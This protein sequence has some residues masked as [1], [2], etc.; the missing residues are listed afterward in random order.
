MYQDER[1]KE[2]NA[3]KEWKKAAVAQKVIGLCGG[4]VVIGFLLCGIIVMGIK[5]VRGESTGGTFTFLCEMLVALIVGIVAVCV[6]PNKVHANGMKKA[7]LW[8]PL[9]VQAVRGQGW[10]LEKLLRKMDIN[11]GIFVWDMAWGLLLVIFIFLEIFCGGNMY[12]YVFIAVEAT[13]LVVGHCVIRSVSKRAKYS[14]KIIKYTEETCG[15]IHNKEQFV[16]W[17]DAEV[18]DRILYQSSQFTLTEN[19]VI[20]R[21]VSDVYCYPV[22]IPKDMI[23]EMSFSFSVSINR[24]GNRNPIGILTCFLQNGKLVKLHLGG[25]QYAYKVLKVLKKYNVNV[26]ENEELTYRY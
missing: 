17:L 19:C 18:R 4:I 22:A 16:Q 25:S 1:E 21:L 9:P 2:Q 5:E 8:E 15:L 23:K 26:S 12:G 7:A 13:I 10:N 24:Y 20:G 6:I 11:I 3:Q 14:K